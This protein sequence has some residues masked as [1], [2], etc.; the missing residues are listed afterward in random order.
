MTV[1]ASLSRRW[2]AGVTRLKIDASGQSVPQGVP[3]RSI[4]VIGPG[5]PKDEWFDLVD[6]AL[7]AKAW[8]ALP[9]ADL[10]E[11][12]QALGVRGISPA[13]LL[14]APSRRPSDRWSRLFDVAVSLALL[15][16]LSPLLLLIGVGVLLSGPGSVL[17]STLVIGRSGA[18][19]VWHKFRSMRPEVPADDE[20]RQAA[21]ASFVRGELRGS[22]DRKVVA[23][24]RVTRFGAWLRRHS[25]DELPQLWSV[26][27][28]DMALV[29]PRPC[30]PYEKEH[31]SGWRTRRFAVR[32]GMTGLWQVY[33]RSRVG[34]DESV[35]MDVLYAYVKRP[36]LDFHLVARTASVVVRGLGGR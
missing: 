1:A 18:T 16:G 4:V 10:G 19:F 13:A 15:V 28:G 26:L 2:P 9:A 17:Y 31:Y 12:G 11:L 7:T 29:G 22:P 25:L 8:V 36:W 30:L 27:V 33:G 21:F 32:P 34:F 5:V 14:L 24:E 35:V 3:R 23:E 20:A 6:A